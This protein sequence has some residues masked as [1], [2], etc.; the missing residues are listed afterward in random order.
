MQLALEA[1]DSIGAG[2]VIVTG[3]PGE[4]YDITFSGAK[5]NANF[6]TQAFYSDDVFSVNNSTT[7]KPGKTADID[8]ATFALRDALANNT[9]AGLELEIELTEGGK[10]TTV[11]LSPC[12]VSE[13]L[14]DA[15]AFS[16]TVGYPSFIFQALTAAATNATTSL[17]AI[18]ALNWTA[19]AN[20]EYLV[21]WNL[22][23]Y[24]VSDADFDGQITAPAGATIYGKWVVCNQ[25][26][27]KYQPEDLLLSSRENFALLDVDTISQSNQKAYIKT[28]STAGTV[29]F[30]FAKNVIAITGYANEIQEGSWVRVEKIA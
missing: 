23:L 22:F 30:S 21:E 20:S 5:S 24:N 4:Y 29:S 3:I 12:T 13:E 27:L 10:R 26:E 2:G 9:S 18:T 8:F 15:D 7:A 11:V 28:G 25:S 1:L 6:I 19:Q 14:I 17:V 16:P